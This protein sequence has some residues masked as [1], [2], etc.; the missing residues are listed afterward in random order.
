MV[1]AFGMV[2][3]QEYQIDKLL[4]QREALTAEVSQLQAQ[5]NEWTKRGG[6][7]KLQKCGDADRLCVR[8]DTRAGSFGK[9]GDYMVLRG[10]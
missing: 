7:V 10:Y 3:W 8:V 2:K 6:R 9:D 4:E 5:A 1:S